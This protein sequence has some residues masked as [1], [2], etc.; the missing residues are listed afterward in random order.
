[1]LR[2]PVP[3]PSAHST[4]D[5]RHVAGIWVNVGR[6]DGILWLGDQLLVVVCLQVPDV[7]STALVTHNEFCLG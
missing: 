5:C 4:V 1:M 6:R 7:D 2:C 3:N